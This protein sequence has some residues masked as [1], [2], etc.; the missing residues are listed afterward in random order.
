[1]TE[2]RVRP[3]RPSR[4]NSGGNLVKEGLAIVGDAIRQRGD[5]MIE[6]HLGR[7]SDCVSSAG[8]HVTWRHAV[9]D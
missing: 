1:V 6:I 2:V 4:V 3:A 7:R 5:V 9:V 8:L